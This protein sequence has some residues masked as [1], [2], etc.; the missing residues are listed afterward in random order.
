M[1]FITYLMLNKKRARV[2]SKSNKFICY[3]IKKLLV[4]SNKS[5]KVA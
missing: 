1:V 3:D 5:S 4:S 2:A